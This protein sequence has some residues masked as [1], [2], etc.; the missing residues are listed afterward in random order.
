MRR[1]QSERMGIRTSQLLHNT[2]G[3]GAMDLQEPGLMYFRHTLDKS[4]VNAHG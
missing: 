2:E 4:T 3:D 1:W